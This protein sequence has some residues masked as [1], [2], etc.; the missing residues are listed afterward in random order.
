MSGIEFDIVWRGF[1]GCDRLRDETSA[2]LTIVVDGEILTENHDPFSRSVRKD[3]YVSIYPLACWIATNW[4]RLLFETLE[5]GSDIGASM[6]SDWRM[7]HELPAANAGYSW[8]TIMFATDQE[9]MTVW[10]E[11]TRH[12]EE[13][14]VRYLNGLDPYRRVETNHFVAQLRN[15]IETCIERLDARELRSSDLHR[16]WVCV[17]EDEADEGAFLERRVEAELGFDPECAPEILVRSALGFRNKWGDDAFSELIPAF[18]AQVRECESLSPVT[19]LLDWNGPIGTPDLP[20][21]VRNDN[22]E[23][24][25][26]WERG[27]RDAK[28]LRRAIGREN[29][30]MDHSCLAD[31]LGL[32]EADARAWAGPKGQP[33]ASARPIT[34]RKMR[35]VPRKLHPLSQRFEKARLVADLIVTGSGEPPADARLL[36]STDARTIRQQYQRAFAAELLCPL[37]GLLEFLDNDYSEDKRAAA[38]DHFTVSSRVVENVLMNNQY[39]PLQYRSDSLPYDHAA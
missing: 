38:A 22:D 31:L 10:A 29:A 15:V 3:I 18:K 11:P 5:V 32:S 13:R 7:S 26:P 6:L 9:F 23:P 34:D 2:D 36:V 16:L 8:P 1:D 19:T 4:W 21:V 14:S 25:R 12:R 20:A 35:Y 27:C 37:E 24:A 30:A 17:R 33:V 39:L 28:A